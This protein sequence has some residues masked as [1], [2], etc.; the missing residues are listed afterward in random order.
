MTVTPAKY[1]LLFSGKA[2]ASSDNVAY[3]EQ[4]MDR[5]GGI[6]A[7]RLAYIKTYLPHVWT[8]GT[9]VLR[10]VQ[11]VACHTI[12]QK[13]GS[14]DAK[15]CKYPERIS[16]DKVEVFEYHAEHTDDICCTLHGHHASRG[17]KNCF[18]R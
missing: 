18:L 16:P 10:Y 5:Y 7:I 13:D 14:S 9:N 8:P 1:V 6:D 11:C 12:R 2:I 3:L 15:P 17:H 4:Q